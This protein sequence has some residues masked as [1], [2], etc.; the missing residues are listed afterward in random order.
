M[1]VDP[2][3]P[4][5]V[6]AYEW[7]PPLAVG[8]VKDMRV[9]WALEEIGVPYRERLFGGA[10]GE[11]SAEHF[12]DQPFG[13]VPVYREADITLFESGAILLHIGAKDERL[14]PRDEAARARG[15]SWAFAALNSIE[16]FVQMLFMMGFA[17]DGKD[18]QEAGKDSVRPFAQMRLAQLSGALGE[19]EWLEDRF[20]IGDLLMVDVLRAVPE[21]ELVAAHPNLAAYLDRGTSRPAFKAAMAAQ[22]AA[23]ERHAPIAA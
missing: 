12:A 19:R 10:G 9:R 4:I 5:E 6:S 8:F 15:I 23:F 13:Q 14:L 7:V 1:P 21:M 17:A 16:P 3:A 22:L 2:N 20:T 18:W 11:K